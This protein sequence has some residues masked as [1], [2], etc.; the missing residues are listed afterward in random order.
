MPSTTAAWAAHCAKDLTELWK[1]L[2]VWMFILLSAVSKVSYGVFF[3]SKIRIIPHGEKP[4]VRRM[5]M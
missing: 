4:L 5:Q 1:Q 3:I 2:E